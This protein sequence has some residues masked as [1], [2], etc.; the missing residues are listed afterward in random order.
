MPENITLMP[1]NITLI[2]VNNIDNTQWQLISAVVKK[3]STGWWHELEN[4]WIVKGGGNAKSWSDRLKPITGL[5]KNYLLVLG[6]PRAGQ[7][8]WVASLTP[9]AVRWLKENFSN[10]SRELPSNTLQDT[11][12]SDPDADELLGNNP[13][14]K[15]NL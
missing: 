7:R 3:E 9:S 12:D 15:D 5:P 2:I 14:S 4:T 6:L 1:E 11:L 13:A 8:S 10:S